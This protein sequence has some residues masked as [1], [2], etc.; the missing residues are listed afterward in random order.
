LDFD[1]IVANYFASMAPYFNDKEISDT[2]LSL[3]VL[4][5]AM[6]IVQTLE[7]D[8]RMISNSKIDILPILK[9]FTYILRN[10][11]TKLIKRVK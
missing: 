11:I 9:T 3:L 5:C 10:D 2:E 4:D 1:R 8:M 7:I 6:L